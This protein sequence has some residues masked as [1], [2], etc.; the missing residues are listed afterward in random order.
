M[1]HDPMAGSR[2]YRRPI[3]PLTQHQIQSTSTDTEEAL[4]FVRQSSARQL[5]LAQAVMDGAILAAEQVQNKR[6]EIL[7]LGPEVTGFDILL[8][9]AL[10]FALESPLAGKILRSL[11]MKMLLPRLRANQLARE[12]ALRVIALPRGAKVTPGNLASP[13]RVAASQLARSIEDLRRFERLLFETGSQEGRYPY[14]VGFIKATREALNKERRLPPAFEP[15]DTPGVAILDLA[16]SHLSRQRLSIQVEQAMFELW[17]RTGQMSI[18]EVYQQLSWDSLD[19]DGRGFSLAEVKDS[20]KRYFELLIWALLLYE[21][22]FTGKFVT[23]PRQSFTLRGY[24]QSSLIEYWLRRF[25]NPETRK[26][27]AETPSL[28]RSDG[29]PDL[30]RSIGVLGNYM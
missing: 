24:V 8:D 29:K 23:T 13:V 6:L 25:L 17:V 16:Q 7:E 26:P 20:Y 21:R 30:D 2:V 22:P 19:V 1:V 9:F 11:T 14:L 27:F 4:A 18:I 12:R 15:S 10:T 3:A 5:E 28:K